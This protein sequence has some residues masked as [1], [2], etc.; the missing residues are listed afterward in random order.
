MQVDKGEPFVLMD[1]MTSKPS[2]L[3]CTEFVVRYPQAEYLDLQTGSYQPLKYI[4]ARSGYKE[5]DCASGEIDITRQANA[6]YKK[7]WLELVPA[8]YDGRLLSSARSDS[9]SH[10]FIHIEA[11]GSGTPPYVEES[12][13]NFMA[14]QISG[15]TA[16]SF[17]KP[18]V[19]NNKIVWSKPVRLFLQP[20]EVLIWFPSMRY[21]REAVDGCSLSSTLGFQSPAPVMYLENLQRDL[22]SHLTESGGVLSVTEIATL[23]SISKC[24]IVEENGRT[25]VR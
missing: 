10:A 22:S 17:S 13:M 23:E 8:S 21:H 7:E 18:I 2:E 12:C 9:S 25:V 16:W 5:L 19:E 24:S 6:V 3:D 1:A 15:V 4:S 20:G 11:S 14:A